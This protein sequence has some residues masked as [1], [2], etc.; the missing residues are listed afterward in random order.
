MSK[1]K[2]NKEKQKK[3]RK[4]EMETSEGHTANKEKF[5]QTRRNSL[6]Q[7]LPYT[8]SPS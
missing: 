4:R 7:V 8:P 1:R 6:K 5:T 3:I 2:V